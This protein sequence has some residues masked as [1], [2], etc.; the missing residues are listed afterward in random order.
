MPM[1]NAQNP[2]PWTKSIY[3]LQLI[4]D[5]QVE[6]QSQNEMLKRDF[7]IFLELNETNKENGEN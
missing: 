5:A 3:L 6:I 4:C 7:C 2:I 1:F